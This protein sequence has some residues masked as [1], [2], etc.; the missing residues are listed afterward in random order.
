MGSHPMGSRE[1]LLKIAYVIKNEMSLSFVG[2]GQKL[3][4]RLCYYKSERKDNKPELCPIT[5]GVRDFSK[6]PLTPKLAA[7]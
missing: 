2:V 5:L 4:G 3:E 7:V 6:S 1:T